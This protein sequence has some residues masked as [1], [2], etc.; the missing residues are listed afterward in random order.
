MFLYFIKESKMVVWSEG[1]NQFSV[2]QPFIPLTLLHPCPSRSTYDQPDF[3]MLP[4]L[5]GQWRRK[6]TVLK[7]SSPSRGIGVQERSEVASSLR[8]NTAYNA[9]TPMSPSFGYSVSQLNL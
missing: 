7:M 4:Q 6:E 3:N 8:V 1:Q 5:G 2:N 9:R